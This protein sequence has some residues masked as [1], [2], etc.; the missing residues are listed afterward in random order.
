MKMI[1][2]IALNPGPLV[3]RGHKAPVSLCGSYR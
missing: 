3:S 2:L 1:K